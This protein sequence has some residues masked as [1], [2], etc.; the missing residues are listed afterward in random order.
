M[1]NKKNEIVER[2][3]LDIEEEEVED[4]HTTGYIEDILHTTYEMKIRG[5]GSD[6]KEGSPFPI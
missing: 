1:K 6:A 5:H 2:W 3:I 4:L